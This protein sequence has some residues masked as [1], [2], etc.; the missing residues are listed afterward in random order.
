MQGENDPTVAVGK[1]VLD[2]IERRVVDAE[3][4]ANTIAGGALDALDRP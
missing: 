3:G 2:G 1:Q 4:V